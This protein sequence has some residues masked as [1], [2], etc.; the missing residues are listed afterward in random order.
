VGSRRES[1][2]DP[3][4]EW[5]ASYNQ[6]GSPSL[7]ALSRLAHM[8]RFLAGYQGRSA[9]AHLVLFA[10]TQE[11]AYLYRAVQVAASRSAGPPDGA[12]LQDPIGAAV[13]LFTSALRRAKPGTPWYVALQ[14][15]QA[16]VLYT[17][18]SAT[19]RIDHWRIAVRALASFLAVIS[20][21]DRDR[22]A[23]TA[24]MANAR[25][26]IARITGSGKTLA[27]AFADFEAA[28]ACFPPEQQGYAELL[29]DAAR[30]AAELATGASAAKWFDRALGLF[31]RA[32]ASDAGVAAAAADDVARLAYF[33]FAEWR[34][35]HRAG[36]LERSASGWRAAAR[37]GGDDAGRLAQNLNNLVATLQEAR[38][39][40]DRPGLLDEQLATLERLVELVPDAA[41]ARRQ[42]LLGLAA[43]YR[44]RFRGRHQRA[45]IDAAIDRLTQAVEGAA[46]GERRSLAIELGGSLRERHLWSGELADVDA[47]LAFWRR[48]LGATS[49]ADPDYPE[50]LGGII[51]TLLDRYSR[52]LRAEDLDAA[53]AALDEAVRTVG[54]ADVPEAYRQR[55]RELEAAAVQERYRELGRAAD[56]ERLLRHSREALRESE[57]GSPEATAR[58]ADHAFLLFRR[59][60]RDS[61][62]GDLNEAITVL[63]ESAPTTAGDAVRA[64]WLTLLGEGL[65]NRYRLWGA[66]QLDELARARE[67]F[68]GAVALA[69]AGTHSRVEALLGLA[70]ATEAVFRLT[71]IPV[72]DRELPVRLLEEAAGQVGADLAYAPFVWRTLADGLLRRA[73][74]GRQQPGDLD[75]AIDLLERAAS[76]SK[77]GFEAGGGQLELADALRERY[78]RSSRPR[79]RQRAIAEY[80]ASLPARLET[81]VDQA[82][83]GAARWGGW[84]ASRRSWPEAA[85]AFALAMRALDEIY[86]ANVGVG[87]TV[88]LRRAPGLAAEAAYAFARAGRPGDSALVLEA[89]RFRAGSESLALVH[90][91]LSQLARAGYAELAGR[92]RDCA[93]QWRRESLIADD[94]PPAAGQVSLSVSFNALR[95]AANLAEPQPRA[96][97]EPG[98]DPG[99]SHGPR[100]GDVDRRGWGATGR[101]TRKAR[102][103]LEE[104]VLAIRA[105]AGFERF[106]D[107]PTLSDITA[108]SARLPVVYLASCAQGG[109]VVAIHPDRP[110][111]AAFLPGLR[112]PLLDAEVA[113]FQEAYQGR[114]TDPVRWRT[115]LAATTRWLW[116]AAMG[117]ALSLAGR[118]GQVLLIPAGALGVLPLHAAWRPDARARTG[119][120]HACD[121][122]VIS[123]APNARSAASAPG[124]AGDTLLAVADPAPLPAPL[125]PLTFAEPEVAAAAA[126][127]PEATVLRH[128]EATADRVREALKAASVYHLACHGRVDLREPRRSA[129][130]LAGGQPLALRHLLDLRLDEGVGRRLAILT[131]CETALA[132]SVLPDEVISLPGALLQAGFTGVVATQW[133]V[134]GLPAAFLAARFYLHWKRDNLD[135][136]TSLAAAQRWL[137]DST[138]G[139]KA[140]FTHPREGEALLPLEARRPLWRAVAQR[141]PAGRSF[142][143]IADWGAYTY[144]GGVGHDG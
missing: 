94:S 43:S 50:W 76:A 112:R 74:S 7:E 101:T 125:Q 129:L 47:S 12:G 104:A 70:S 77:G 95:E 64:R 139:E 18:A 105:V 137:R 66:G 63:E 65:L 115:Q 10:L 26:E 103:E 48:M 35:Q 116:D 120:R 141:D 73:G 62:Q 107:E 143:D 24:T 60:D 98:R 92:L 53:V 3:L 25:R 133:A 45:D 22:P 123:Y 55:L 85:E 96:A 84:A 61:D 83:G 17:R 14:R 130:M 121:R 5:K 36:D 49:A 71:P 33:Y 23:V 108:A 1:S 52:S 69:P 113:K 100:S 31:E 30:T 9:D 135:W 29:A 91:D 97:G 109:L 78:R 27:T 72:G 19:S 41:P 132:G 142:A 56:L 79:D 51:G 140:E 42:Y 46:P 127:F 89:A 37:I 134:P 88:W 67:C 32:A 8:S 119:R 57:P 111:R 6:G 114:E 126:W 11:A 58:A 39:D 20:P 99:E 110:A 128:E 15:G 131:A 144:I 82:L 124:G 138:D 75:R 122:V 16:R 118:S 2:Y 117:P 136:A 87:S 93:A 80:R 102:K 13:P 21:D 34:E 28:V 106:L 4:E 40:H 59:F 54:G 38:E 86:L 68:E 81:N 44:D 90:A